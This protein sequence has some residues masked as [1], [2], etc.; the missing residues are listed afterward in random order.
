M[1]EAHRACRP[2]CRLDGCHRADSDDARNV[3]RIAPEL[4][5]AGQEGQRSTIFTRLSTPARR[6]RAPFG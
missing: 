5:P 2:L 4:A 1:A 3:R 6:F